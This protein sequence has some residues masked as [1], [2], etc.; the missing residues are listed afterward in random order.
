MRQHAEDERDREGYVAPDAELSAD[1]VAQ[2]GSDPEERRVHEMV[3]ERIELEESEQHRQDENLDGSHPHVVPVERLECRP[4]GRFSRTG[5]VRQKRPVVTVEAETP[6]IQRRRAYDDQE[7]EQRIPE[8]WTAY[9][10]LRG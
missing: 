6:E 7:H 8:H 2:H 5:H 10:E 3:S 9:S 4:Y 1:Q